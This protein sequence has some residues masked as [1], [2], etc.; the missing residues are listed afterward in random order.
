[1][2]PGLVAPLVLWP[3]ATNSQPDA[4][5]IIAAIVVVAVGMYFKN[6][7]AAMFS[8]GIALYLILYLLGQ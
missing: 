3:E 6:V 4:A 5:R 7:L 8:G 1:M 2:L